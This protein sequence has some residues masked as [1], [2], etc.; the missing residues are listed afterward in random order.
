MPAADDPVFAL[1]RASLDPTCHTAAVRSEHPVCRVVAATARKDV[2]AGGMENISFLAAGVAFAGAAV[3]GLFA[4]HYDV[5][6]AKLMRDLLATAAE[7]RR[8]GRGEDVPWQDQVPAV[9]G[10]FFD[11]ATITEAPAIMARVWVEGENRFYDLLVDL[12]ALTATMMTSLINLKAYTQEEIFEEIGRILDLTG[13]ND[14]P[15]RP[16]D[17]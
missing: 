1:L 13:D 10:A 3:T 11:P 17:D 5:E 2:A 8:K 9:L 6:P 14:D 15:S 12:A 16:T 7:D 4:E